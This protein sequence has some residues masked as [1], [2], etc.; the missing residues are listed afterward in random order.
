MITQADIDHLQ[1][2]QKRLKCNY[3]LTIDDI[4]WLALKLRDFMQENYEL[5]G[6]LKNW[7]LNEPIEPLTVE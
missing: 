7:K 2:I 4:K 1:R 3:P 6:E 5:P